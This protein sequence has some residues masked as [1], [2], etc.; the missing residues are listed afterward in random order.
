MATTA[1]A[2]SKHQQKSS[3]AKLLRALKKNPKL[4]RSKS[5]LRRANHVNFK[6][7]V[8]I[9]LNPDATMPNNLCQAVVGH[10]FCSG[11]ITGN[12]LAA[13]TAGTKGGIAASND[14]ASLNLGQSL[15]GVKPLKLAGQVEAYVQFADPLDG[16]KLGDVSISFKD[17][18]AATSKLEVNPVSLLTNS[19]VTGTNVANG[20]CNDRG[21]AT[22]Y[23]GGGIFGPVP[24]SLN[25][26]PT[27]ALP[28]GAPLYDVD[29]PLAMPYM[30]VSNTTAQ[31]TVLS[32]RGPVTPANPNGN[33]LVGI[34]NARSGG[35]ANILGAGPSSVNIG[36]NLQLWTVIRAVDALRGDGTSTTP[37]GGNPTSTGPVYDP[38][39]TNCRQ[40][41]TGYIDNKLIANVGGGNSSVKIA[42]AFTLDH[43][44]RIAKLEFGGETTHQTVA[45]CLQPFTSY[46]KV[47]DNVTL[48][49]W[50]RGTP[51][52]TD[53]TPY[54]IFNTT[55]APGNVGG[56]IAAS[57]TSFVT[58]TTLPGKYV[59][60]GAPGSAV[61]SV[62]ATAGTG[63]NCDNYPDNTGTTMNTSDAFAG[64]SA[65]GPTGPTGPTWGSP[66]IPLTFTGSPAGPLFSQVP[67]LFTKLNTGAGDCTPDPDR[68]PVLSFCTSY[69]QN[70]VAN[71]AVVAADLTVTSLTAEILIGHG[72]SAGIH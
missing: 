14:V 4:I 31:N 49:N 39:D 6:L 28:T 58:G 34:D 32:A 38:F 12:T 72:I 7:P 59:N 43:N 20:G 41:W 18:T 19:D 10:P 35:F 65:W 40:A 64:A 71:K 45:A 36:L 13:L 33:L 52:T 29:N 48:F 56:Q 23:Y 70:A 57:G 53:D 63:G 24:A 44:L 9:R 47:G 61:D 50:D 5:W 30:N 26:A 42:P 51:E 69:S 66:V 37:V 17:T 54:P 46:A 25:Y 68:L 27:G 3:S 62:P 16:G 8:T 55:A 22:N 11:P 67:Y 1:S 60:Q 15:G 2:M 21:A